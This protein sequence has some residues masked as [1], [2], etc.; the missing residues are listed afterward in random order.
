MKSRH[1]NRP[2]NGKG[3]PPVKEASLLT[4]NQ[5]LFLLVLLALPAAAF[6]K[7]ALAIDWRVLMIP[8]V[9]AQLFAY[10]SIW[11]D[12]RRAI[13]GEWRL[14]ESMLHTFELLGGWP[15]GFLAQRQFRHKTSKRRYQATFWLIVATYQ[16]TAVDFLLN[17]WIARTIAEKVTAL[18]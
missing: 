3:A 11:R 6:W 2:R 8:L 1:P 5:W 15:A 14:P 4:S 17:W 18:F 10:T 12:K 16:Y 9:P 7:L 13:K